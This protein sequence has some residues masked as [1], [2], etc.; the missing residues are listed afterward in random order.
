MSQRSNPQGAVNYIPPPDLLKPPRVFKGGP[1]YRVNHWWAVGEV[2]SWDI[3]D[4]IMPY[5]SYP[6]QR[7][8]VSR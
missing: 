2:P 7:V 6:D 5:Q 8:V 4:L 1:V 3:Q